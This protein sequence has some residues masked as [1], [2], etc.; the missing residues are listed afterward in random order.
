LGEAFLVALDGQRG[1]K[2]TLGDVDMDNFFRLLDLCRRNGVVEGDFKSSDSYITD[3]DIR[4]AIRRR[5]L[6]PRVEDQTIHESALP[7]E[8]QTVD[9]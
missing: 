4:A 9:K 8:N 5:G 1:L 7:P 3:D 6:M 2:P